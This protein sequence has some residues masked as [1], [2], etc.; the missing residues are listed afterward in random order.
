[1][2]Q[3]IYR[4]LLNRDT[5]ICYILARIAAGT[6]FMPDNRS[7]AAKARGNRTELWATTQQKRPKYI[8]AVRWTGLI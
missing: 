8:A 6:M 2:D 4:L 5:F 1:M 3:T 7:G